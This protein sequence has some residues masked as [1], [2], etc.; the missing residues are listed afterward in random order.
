MSNTYDYKALIEA[1]I[2]LIQQRHLPDEFKNY[3]VGLIKVL[4]VL[5]EM[6]LHPPEEDPLWN[7]LAHGAEM[8]LPSLVYDVTEFMGKYV[9]HGWLEGGPYV[10]LA[11]L[12]ETNAQ[13]KITFDAMNAM[14]EHNKVL[15]ASCRNLLYEV[16]KLWYG[17]KTNKV[18]ASEDLL[19]AGFDDSNP[20]DETDWY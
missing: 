1:E 17:D 11:L 14:Y 3:Y 10:T 9:T 8:T 5:L 18:V 20:P 6:K 15:R 16:F 7:K 19:K 12:K 2:T 13:A 4:E